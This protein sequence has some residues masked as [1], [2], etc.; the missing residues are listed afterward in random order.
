MTHTL[1]AGINIYYYTII[2]CT[3]I[4]KYHHQTTDVQVKVVDYNTRNLKYL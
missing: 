4:L 2:L 3:R 1:I